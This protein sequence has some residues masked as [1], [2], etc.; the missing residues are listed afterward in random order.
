[1]PAKSFL[2]QY[3]LANEYLENWTREHIMRINGFT[4][5]VKINT[6]QKCLKAWEN[7]R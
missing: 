2:K 1:M 4:H 7:R 6:L 5:D 3:R